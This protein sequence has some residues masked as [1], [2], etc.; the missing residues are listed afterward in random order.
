MKDE[1]DTVT[2]EIFIPPP[3]VGYRT[4]TADDV[5]VINGIKA[6]AGELYDMLRFLAMMQDADETKPS[7]KRYDARWANIAITHLQLA[8]MAGVR[9]VA[10]P[11]GV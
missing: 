1:K 7:G 5:K 9:A 3:I 2:P 8:A 11:E 4:L 6:K 10:Q